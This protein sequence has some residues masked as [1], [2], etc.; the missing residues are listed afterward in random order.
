MREDLVDGLPN[1]LSSCLVGAQVDPCAGP[2]NISR[3]LYL[4]FG[5]TC[6]D[7]RNAV[8]DRHVNTQNNH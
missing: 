3:D 5:K 2:L 8:E 6:G 1:G 4:V 7:N